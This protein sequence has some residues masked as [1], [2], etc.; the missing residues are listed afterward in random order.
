[1]NSRYLLA[2]SIVMVGGILI[3]LN[4][5]SMYDYYSYSSVIEQSDIYSDII[6]VDQIPINLSS[7]PGAI[8]EITFLK[9][10]GSI[11][12]IFDNFDS[13]L[14]KNVP[15]FTYE[16]NFVKGESFIFKCDY[17]DSGL[18]HFSL[19][20]YGG[21]IQKDGETML[22]MIS[23]EGSTRQHMMCDYPDVIEHSVNRISLSSYLDE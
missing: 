1:M 5:D 23:G 18:T 7:Y 10:D 21:P 2:L 3:T 13:S 12:V 17:S 4:F 14:L 6:H 20:E 11:D 19:F 15:N 9:K 16:R 22:V 8:K